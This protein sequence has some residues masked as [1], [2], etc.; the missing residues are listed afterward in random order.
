MLIVALDEETD[1]LA[2]SADDAGGGFGGG[3]LGNQPEGLPAASGRGVGG[4]LVA[5]I[6]FVDR[7]VS[8]KLDSAC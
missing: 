7:Q 8:F 1:P 2:A 3:T 5:L 6:E 4:R